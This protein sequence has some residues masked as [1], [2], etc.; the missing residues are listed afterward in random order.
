MAAHRKPRRLV[1]LVAALCVLVGAAVGGYALTGSSAPETVNL[2][3]ASAAS[4]QHVAVTAC[5]TPGKFTRVSVTAGP[6]C[7]AKSAPVHW[8]AQSGP[9]AA[10]GQHVAVYA[11]LASGKLTR[12]SVAAAPRCSAKSVSVRWAAWS[13]R[14][15][16]SGQRVT[17]YACLASGK[18]T[19][20][21]VAAAPR[22]PAKSVLVRWVAQSGP[23]SS[24]S[25]MPRPSSSS[26]S[27][28]SSPSSSPSSPVPTT[29]SPSTVP[30]TT[31]PSTVPTTASPSP[32]PSTTSPSP[33]RTTTSPSPTQTSTA[34]ASS[35]WCS[36]APFGQSN[37]P[38]GRFDLYN[39]E[40]NTS[41]NPGPQTICGNSESDWQVT[42]TQRAGN[43]EVLTY[44]SVQLNYNGGNGY[45]LSKFTSM[46]S[47]YA[48]NMH[49][50]SGTDA[51]AAYDIWLNGLNKEVM[52]W[53]D[54]HG[55]APA[56][57]KVATTTFSGATWDLYET[58]DRSYLA[59]VREGNASSGTVD[60]LAALKFLQG[61][62]DL[63]AGDVLWQ[64]NFGWEICSTAGAPE[65]FTVSN[66]SLTSAPSS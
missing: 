43:T 2:A 50:V 48:E 34:P 35:A 40:W 65:T 24:P 6:K 58:S 3:S 7:P 47:S 61:R 39:N 17:I 45:P 23:A 32:V 26:S 28:P 27:S 10:S 63:A 38:D 8:V 52:I 20:I 18:L 4:G 14:S 12:V 1:P 13:G 30:T 33:V 19:R 31:S 37:T 36:S 21:S 11:C 42:S 16:A 9:S 64:V 62:G 46:T 66:Y 55:Q 56:G 51:E 57:S 59:F 25:P 15:A 53:V 54:N 49:A 29:T 41:A 44:P 22:C 60:L 5:L